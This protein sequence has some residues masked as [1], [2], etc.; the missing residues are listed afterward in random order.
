MK[1]EITYCD[2]CGDMV[3][4]S[5]QGT[6]KW[7]KIYKK[8]PYDVNSANKGES[9]VLCTYCIKDFKAGAQR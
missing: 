1:A 4:I 8:L 5:N 7:F 6:I 3:Y 9:G 2:H